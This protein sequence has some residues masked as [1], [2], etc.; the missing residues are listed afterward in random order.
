MRL[1]DGGYPNSLLARRLT[2]DLLMAVRHMGN[3]CGRGDAG[4]STHASP[5]L[6]LH[7]Q[8]EP[9]PLAR[10]VAWAGMGST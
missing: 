8:G 6:A 10:Q 2:G 4:R 1:E 7:L 9:A 5:R 3:D